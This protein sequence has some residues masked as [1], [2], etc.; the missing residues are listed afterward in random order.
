MGEWSWSVVDLNGQ[1]AGD[2]GKLLFVD[3]ERTPPSGIPVSGTATYDARTLFGWVK[4]PFSLVADFGQR[5]I[6][7]RI[8]QDYRYDPTGDIMDYPLAAGIH[9]SGSA[10]FSNSGTFDIP[11][12]GTVNYSSGYDINTPLAPPSTA[13]TGAMNGA[14]FGPHAEQVGGTFSLD[15]SN[16][17]QVFEDAFVGRQH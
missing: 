10:P 11:L 3:G 8:D 6:S 15:R 2:S 13:V 4:V 14:F 17:T 1:A 9:V 5:S 12:T 7:T 16:G